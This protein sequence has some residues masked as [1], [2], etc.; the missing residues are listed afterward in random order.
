MKKVVMAHGIEFVKT[1]KARTPYFVPALNA[2]YNGG[3]LYDIAANGAAS[4]QVRRPD[5]VAFDKG[6]DIPEWRASVKSRG[7]TIC[8]FRKEC[9]RDELLATFEQMDASNR[10]IWADDLTDKEI[11]FYIMTKAE[12]FGLLKNFAKLEKIK[13]K[14]QVVGTKLRLQKSGR[15]LTKAF[16]KYLA[17]MVE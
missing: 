6:S 8:E 17:D 7:C 12:F 14:G 1:D 3:Q 13:K 16:A 15:P 4:H 11:T 9:T 5:P 10:Y 2:Y